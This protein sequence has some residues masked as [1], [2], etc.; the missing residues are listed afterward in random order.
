LSGTRSRQTG[1][2]GGWLQVLQREIFVGRL[3]RKMCAVYREIPV[4]LDA[5][6]DV[7]AGLG[8]H[9]T[10]RTVRRTANQPLNHPALK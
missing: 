7:C 3:E 5:R 2:R 6:L 10:S 1:T 8:R 4:T 9:D